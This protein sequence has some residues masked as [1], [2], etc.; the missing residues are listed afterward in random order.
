MAT[1][2][3]NFNLALPSG[4]EAPDIEVINMNMEKIDEQMKK[5]SGL[6]IAGDDIEEQEGR[7]MSLKTAWLDLQ[8]GFGKRFAWSD[9]KAIFYD[10]TKNKKLSTKLKDMDNVVASAYDPTSTYNFMDYCMYND[11]MYMCIYPMSTAEEWNPEHW[12][13]YNI[14]DAF[15]EYDKYLWNRLGGSDGET[16]LNTLPDGI[17]YYNGHATNFIG[18]KP[19]SNDEGIWIRRTP[20]GD[21]TVLE[22]HGIDI[23]IRRNG[24]VYYRDFNNSESFAEWGQQGAANIAYDNSSSGMTATNVQGALDELNNNLSKVTQTLA[25]GVTLEYNK[26]V[27]SLKIKISSRAFTAGWNKVGT[28]PEEARPQQSVYFCLADDTVNSH[29]YSQVVFGWINGGGEV[30]IFAYADRLT[31]A[32]SGS[33]TYII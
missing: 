5:N 3:D 31:L 33:V 32:P 27:A 17:Y 25:T 22:M 20:Y 15:K 21:S 29:V 28:I 30:Q 26:Y 9:V 12:I 23:V 13:E 16:N 1:Y 19:F 7:R 24:V 10:Y 4:Q 8:D 18:T 6:V 14:E 2:T 11:K